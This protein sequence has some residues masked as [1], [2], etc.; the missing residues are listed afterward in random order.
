[1]LTR[2]ANKKANTDQII[3]SIF[4][5]PTLTLTVIVRGQGVTPVY[6]SLSPTSIPYLDFSYSYQCVIDTQ[7]LLFSKK[8]SKIWLVEGGVSGE[9]LR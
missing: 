2:K 9:L 7:I 5:Q 4:T 8:E 6:P 3:T 1:M